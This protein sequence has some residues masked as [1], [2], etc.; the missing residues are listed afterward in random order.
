MAMRQAG[1]EAAAKAGQKGGSTSQAQNQA[2]TTSK[3]PTDTTIPAPT[4]A[5]RLDTDAEEVTKVETGAKTPEQLASQGQKKT[6]LDK[7]G[8]SPEDEGMSLPLPLPP[9]RYTSFVTRTEPR[10]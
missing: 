9:H 7:L 2:A 6:S 10:N 4:A 3:D 5:A 1:A 8:A